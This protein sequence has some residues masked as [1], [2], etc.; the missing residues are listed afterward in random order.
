MMMILILIQHLASACIRTPILQMRK[1]KIREFDLPR[2]IHLV[3]EQDSNP[4]LRSPN[5]HALVPP[6]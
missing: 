4:D 5:A 3:S 2:A 1:L 6:T